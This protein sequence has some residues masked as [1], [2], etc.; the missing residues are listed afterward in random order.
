[1]WVEDRAA[2]PYV[3]RRLLVASDTSSDDVQIVAAELF[4]WLKRH[5]IVTVGPPFIR[6]LVSHPGM[7]LE[8][9]VGM[10]VTIAVP[11]IAPVIAGTLPAGRYLVQRH[12]GPLVDFRG[13]EAM[14]DRWAAQHGP[15][16][17]REPVHPDTIWRG[18]VERFLTSPATEPDPSKWAIEVAYLLNPSTTSTPHA[19]G[20]GGAA[21]ITTNGHEQ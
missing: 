11:A 16:A 15:A 21:T 8:I 18:R 19:N 7:G 10:A 4:G 17:A 2:E 13:A 9:E 12:R 5:G 14:L 1:V 3:A 20:H 6:Y